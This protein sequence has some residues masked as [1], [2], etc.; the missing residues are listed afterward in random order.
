MQNSRS[1]TS[2]VEEEGKRRQDRLLPIPPSTPFST[3][4]LVEKAQCENH[5]VLSP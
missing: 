5:S 1:G 2:L 4:P 3:L